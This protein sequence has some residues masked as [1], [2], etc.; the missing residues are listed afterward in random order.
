MFRGVVNLAAEAA[1]FGIQLYK[2]R[3]R[4]LLKAL[5]KVDYIES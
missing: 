2:S 3:S 4:M 1:G 5:E